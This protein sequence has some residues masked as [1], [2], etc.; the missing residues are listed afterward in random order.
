MPVGCLL[1]V[2]I[3]PYYKSGIFLM[4]NA[5]NLRKI[6]SILL[7]YHLS[8]ENKAFWGR[9]IDIVTNMM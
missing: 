2:K 4:F 8:V 9:C 1:Y 6:P 5:V 3:P 7:M